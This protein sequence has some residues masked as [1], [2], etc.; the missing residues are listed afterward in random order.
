MLASIMDGELRTLRGRVEEALAR[1]RRV[2]LG[3]KPRWFDLKGVRRSSSVASDS[4]F[5]GVLTRYAFIYGI[6]AF[7]AP[8]TGSS[9]DVIRYGRYL[10]KFDVLELL[11]SFDDEGS[12]PYRDRRGV[13]HH[14]AKDLEVSSAKAVIDSMGSPPDLVL[15]DGSLRSFFYNRFRGGDEFSESLRRSWLERVEALERISRIS[16]VVFI[17]KVHTR[18]ILSRFL[19]PEVDGKPV[20][21]PDYALIDKILEGRSREPGF[22][23]PIEVSEGSVGVRYTL[24]YAILAR[25]APAYQITMPGSLSAEEISEVLE[26]LRFHSAPGYPEPLR[27]CHYHSRIGRKEFLQLLGAYGVRLESGREVLGEL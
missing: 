7:S 13:V 21:V 22:L 5:L 12:N 2:R 20:V 27:Q 8:F 23:E 1:Y 24:T 4:S 9:E 18:Q 26:M 10:A 19:K 15:F 16:R 14:I 11:S 25:G 3:N 6:R 17:S